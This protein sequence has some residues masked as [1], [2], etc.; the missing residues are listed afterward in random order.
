MS[1][2]FTLKGSIIAGA[3]QSA[4]EVF[5]G[6]SAEVPLGTK[7]NGF[8]AATGV[9]RKALS[10]PSAFVEL[11]GVGAGAGDAVTAGRFLYLRSNALVTLR[12]SQQNPGGGADIVKDVPVEGLVALEF[13]SNQA[14]TLLEAQGTATIE[15]LVCGD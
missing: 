9:L 11:S 1:V 15:Y 5:P 4:S 7:Q 14:L 8:Q 6:S 10:S 2:A 13:P 3:A 12:L